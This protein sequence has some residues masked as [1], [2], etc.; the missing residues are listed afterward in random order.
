MIIIVVVIIVV[1]Y[2]FVVA[3]RNNVRYNTKDLWMEELINE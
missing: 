3:I 1:D 2:N